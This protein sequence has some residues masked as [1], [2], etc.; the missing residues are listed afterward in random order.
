MNL[1]DAI[2]LDPDAR[3]CEA[4]LV[5][6]DGTFTSRAF[7]FTQKGK[8]SLFAFAA[9][10]PD[11]LIGIEGINGQSAPIESIFK[12]RGFRVISIPSFRIAMYRTAMV[13]SQ[14][15]NECDARAVA[16]FL[17]DVEAKGRLHEFAERFEPDGEL[18]VLCRERH[19]LGEELT[20]KTN[21]LWKLLKECAN[22]LYLDLA[23]N[24]ENSRTVLTTRR[25]LSLFVSHPEVSAWRTISENDLF[26]DTGKKRL[27]GWDAFVHM[28]H[29]C[30]QTKPISP[31]YRLCIKN[32]AEGMLSVLDQEKLIEQELERVVDDRPL[33]KK[34]RDRYVGIGTYEAALMIEEIID[35]KRFKDDDHLASYAGL[36]K[37]DYS[38]GT[39]T[40]QR[41]T[42]MCNKRL[43]SAFITTAREFLIRNKDDPLARYQRA[44][45]K[46]GMSHLEAQKR[47]A[48][49]LLREIYRFLKNGG[50]MK[51]KEGKKKTGSS[52]AIERAPDNRPGPRATRNSPKNKRYCHGGPGA[53]SK[54]DCA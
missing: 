38:T 11:A 26:T 36:T 34:L 25:L 27:Q 51:E 33:V 53:R 16:D 44:L 14:K 29:S 9:E 1:H 10:V 30:N 7:K 48:R 20:A 13:G 47:V 41:T 23:G 54:R 28:V 35:I 50:E 2:G 39:N 18:R 15:N 5:R 43:K 8:E 49:A 24:D 40:R 31:A 6:R 17:L 32:L 52:V 21:K 42:S 46:R 3:G 22:D 4:C 45:L 19:R 12:E 37:R